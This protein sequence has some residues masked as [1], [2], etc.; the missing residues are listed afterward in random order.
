MSP[1]DTSE[2]DE[3]DRLPSVP[4]RKS[5]GAKPPLP[6]R[7]SS[8]NGRE[9]RFRSKRQFSEIP[10][11]M[12]TRGRRLR[13]MQS[14][15]DENEDS[16]SP[17]LTR[18]KRSS[19]RTSARK[20]IDYEDDDDD[21]EDD[22]SMDRSP[23]DSASKTS[24]GSSS[25]SDSISPG[26]GKKRKARRSV[27]S[28]RK[29]YDDDDEGTNND[30]EPSE[31]IPGQNEIIAQLEEDND[32]EDFRIDESEEE[33][34][35]PKK[36]RERLTSRQRAMQGEHVQLFS[37]LESPKTK[38]KPE[39]VED[40]DD[41]EVELKKQQ[42]ARL[43]QMVHEKRNKEKRA[44]MVDKVLRGVTSKRKKLTMATEARV[45]QV[46]T[47]LTSNEMREGCLRF[48]SNPTGIFVSL[49][50]DVDAPDYLGGS[51]K[52]VYPPACKR[53]PKTGK[54]ILAA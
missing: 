50:K 2:S 10:R 13:K 8:K 5:T 28:E 52:A 45:Q 32:S 27:S 19:R 37:K 48:V 49:P 16:V 36:R 47:R 9:E 42:K 15:D 39:P 24:K 12:K 35:R 17:S 53:D 11:N 51:I 22:D 34:K 30:D 43:R 40:W 26:R 20:V 46:G 21:E 1:I 38:K 18:S 25:K 6:T 33:E 29:S 44:A 14:D 41:E 7:D 23:S 3:I 54:R 31:V 4:R